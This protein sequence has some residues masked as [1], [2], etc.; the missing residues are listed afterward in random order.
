MLEI[1]NT[2]AVSILNISKDKKDKY[3]EDMAKLQDVNQDLQAQMELMHGLE[4]EREQMELHLRQTKIE[5]A[6]VK[7]EKNKEIVKMR[8]ELQNVEN[9]RE[10]LQNKLIYYYDLEDQ[11][12]TTRG[13]VLSFLTLRFPLAAIYA[14]Q[15]GRT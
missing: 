13:F 7:D 1:V 15:C 11:V 10:Y 14:Y 4:L 6:K 8:G 3:V 9:E 5:L 12:G 2:D